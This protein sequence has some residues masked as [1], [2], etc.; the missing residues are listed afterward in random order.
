MLYSLDAQSLHNLST[1]HEKVKG[2]HCIELLEGKTDLAGSGS[3]FWGP[4]SI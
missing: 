1:F 4:Y 3:L 2:Q